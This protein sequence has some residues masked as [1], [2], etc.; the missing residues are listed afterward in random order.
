MIQQKLCLAL[1]I[2]PSQQLVAIGDAENDVEMLE[3]AA[4]GIAVSNAVPKAQAVADIVLDESNDAGGAGVAIEGFG[5]GSILEN[6]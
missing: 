4:I 1:G 2:D 5:L 6:C 3:M